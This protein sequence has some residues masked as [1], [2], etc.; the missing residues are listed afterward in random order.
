MRK[1]IFTIIQ[2]GMGD[3]YLSK[4]YDIFIMIVAVLSIVPM[5]FKKS[6]PAL[7]TIDIVTVYILF[8]DYVFRWITYDYALKLKTAADLGIK[9]HKHLVSL[10]LKPAEESTG[11]RV[12]IPF[13]IYPF[14][15]FAIM[16]LLSLMPSLGVISSGWRILRVLRIFKVLHYSRAFQYIETVFKKESKTLL[17][18]LILALSY[19]FVTALIMFSYE[20]GTFD[21]FFE[22]L[23]WATSA[24]TTVGYGDIYPV[25]NIGR[26]ISMISSLFGIAVIALPAG[27]V[28]AGFIDAFNED[29]K[30]Q[31]KA[32]RKKRKQQKQRKKE[33]ALMVSEKALGLDPETLKQ[34]LRT[35]KDT[36]DTPAGEKEWTDET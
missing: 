25:S 13:I 32:A 28:T 34:D 21:D 17:Y 3:D 11:Q 10:T 24:L 4:L 12:W 19:I 18:V 8:A 16:D 5:M 7:N 27:I 30:L 20:P 22:A 14:S 15:P 26:F 35:E 23:Y 31:A 1:R 29:K 36:S 6:T 33:I 2:R 9:N